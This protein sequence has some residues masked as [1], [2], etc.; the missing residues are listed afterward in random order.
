MQPVEQGLL[1]RRSGQAALASEHGGQRHRPPV[2]A[3]RVHRP[4]E[5]IKAVDAAQL[6]QPAIAG[7][8]LG[9][10]AG[11]DGEGGAA[12]LLQRRALGG[13]EGAL[14]AG[15]QVA[16]KDGAGLLGQAAAEGLGGGAG[17]GDGADAE[18]EARQEDAEAPDPG[19]HLARGE[20]EA[21]RS[22]QV[23]A[24]R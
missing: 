24:S 23:G 12:G 17:R 1:H 4:G 5:R 7:G 19:A 13:G 9:H 20:A 3:P 8:R 15:G 10:R 14:D 11:G 18:S 6:H 21:E 2:G 16:A 22:A